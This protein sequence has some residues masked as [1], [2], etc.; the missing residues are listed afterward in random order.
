MS[1]FTDAITVIFLH[2]GGYTVDHAGATNYGITVPV[3]AAQPDMDGD[4][5]LDG[6]LDHDGDIDADDIRLMTQQ[7][8]ID[9][10][11]HQWWNRYEYSLL[12]SQRL[13]TKVF[14]LSVNMGPGRA[15]RL[16]QMAHNRRPIKN[17]V[18]DGVLGDITRGECNTRHYA[19]LLCLFCCEAW[20]FYQRLMVRNPAWVKFELGWYRRAMWPFNEEG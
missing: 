1:S 17:I 5:W 2:E 20:A 9:I 16:L 15:H 13:A 10:Y 18:V 12:S 6:D 4:G 19:E 14:D 7:D 11:R 8:A 3:L